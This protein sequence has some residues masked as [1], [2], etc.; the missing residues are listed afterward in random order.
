MTGTIKGAEIMVAIAVVYILVTTLVGV[1]SVKYTKDTNSF[2]TGKK[3]MGP[4][5]IG[6]LMMSEFIGTGSTLGTA[7]TAYTKGISAAWNLITLGLGFLLYAFFMAPRFSAL[8]EYTISGALSKKYGNSTRMVVSLIMIYALTV[9]NV[10]MYT[11]GAATFSTILNV[12]TSVAVLI[13]GVVTVINISTGGIRGVGYSN[14]IHTFFKYLGLI[15]TAIV[16][17][18]AC[19]GITNLAATLPPIYFSWQGIGISTIIA[20]TIAN[21]GSVFSTQYVIQSISALETPDEARKASIYA[22]IFIVPIGILA[23]FIG[24][25]AK[26]I[27]PNIKSVMALPQFLSIMGPWLGGI[28]VATLLASTFVSILACQLGSTALFIKDFY[29]PFVKPNERHK[30]IATRVVSI[31]LGLLPIPFALFMPAILN[32]IFFARALRTTIAVVAIAMFYL[33][34]FS[35]SRGATVGLI[36]SVV[37]ASTWFFLHNPWGIDSIYVAAVMPALIMAIDHLFW[38]KRKESNPPIAP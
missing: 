27:F 30:L 11:G 21:I 8:G 14:L 32:T 17:Y 22:S 28:L 6:V 19:G 34:Y 18:R 38:G 25:A 12:P 1:W 23:A 2:M 31:I 26:E 5:I 15:V 13:T 35:S 16:A 7:Q 10:S 9:V 3:M 33:P 20:W 36:C 4:F 37:G 29:I 24:V